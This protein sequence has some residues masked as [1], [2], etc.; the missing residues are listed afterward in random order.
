MR[1]KARIYLMVMAV[2]LASI[3]LISSRMPREKSEGVLN[4][5]K[6]PNIMGV[7]LEMPRAAVAKLHF[8]GLLAPEVLYDADDHVSYVS[9]SQ[10]NDGDHKIL[11]KTDRSVILEGKGVPTR[12]R[13]SGGFKDETEALYEGPSAVLLVSYFRGGAIESIGIAKDE[14]HFPERRAAPEAPEK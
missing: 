10:L 2:V 11:G 12:T 14:A 7:R 5:L 3:Y 6:D 4:H 8:S 9:G 13:A 1:R